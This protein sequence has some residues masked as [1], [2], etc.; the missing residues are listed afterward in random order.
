MHKE[1]SMHT[2]QDVI[3]LKESGEAYKAPEQ[4]I[5]DKTILKDMQWLTLYKHTGMLEVYNELINKYCPKREHFSF[6]G[7]SWH[8]LTALDNNKNVNRKSA[9]KKSAEKK[10]QSSKVTKNWSAIVTS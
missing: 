4:V 6:L 2:R 10:Y 3:W 5:L 7:M 8:Q 1:I 9:R